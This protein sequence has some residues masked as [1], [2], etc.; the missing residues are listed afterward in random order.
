MLRRSARPIQLS[1]AANHRAAQRTEVMPL[2][3]AAIPVHALELP[4]RLAGKSGGSSRHNA[5]AS[6]AEPAEN[7]FLRTFWDVSEIPLDF[8]NLCI[9]TV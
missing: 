7:T 4:Q 2:R 8:R 9:E 5:P 6:E 1:I 3:D